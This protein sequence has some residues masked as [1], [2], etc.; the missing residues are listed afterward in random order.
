M[1]TQ[2]PYYL[3]SIGYYTL[4]SNASA[5]VAR[6]GETVVRN[7]GICQGAIAPNPKLETYP[8]ETARKIVCLRRRPQA[9]T[10]SNFCCSLA[11]KSQPCPKDGQG[12]CWLIKSV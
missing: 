4:R 2:R 10:P 3:R 1:L 8:L 5:V 9:H 7:Q 6:I 12:A 11:T